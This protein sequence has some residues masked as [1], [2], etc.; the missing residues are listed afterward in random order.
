MDAADRL[1]ILDLYGRVALSI[2]DGDDAAWG[3]CFSADARFK[4][5]EELDL[6]GRE[7]LVSFARTHHAG[8]SGAVR[9]NVT[10]VSVSASPGGAT[11]CAYALIS[12]G[13]QVVASVRYEDELVK[14]DG[15]WR[16]ASRNVTTTS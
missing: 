7:Q 1:E 12:L 8:P 14:E 15:A 16:F 9:H 5:G 10:T 13:A 6:A 4:A 3:Q 11:G 2:D